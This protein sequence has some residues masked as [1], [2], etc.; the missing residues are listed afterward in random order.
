MPTAPTASALTSNTQLATTAYADTAVGVEATRAT[1]A[2]ALKAPLA[3]PA[4]TGTPTAPTKTALTNSTAIATTAYAD[5]AVAVVSLLTVTLTDAG[6]I[7][8]G[9]SAG[10]S[11]RVTLGGNRTLGNPSSPAYDG[12]EI[13][14]AV[15]QPASGGP[16]TLSYDT[17]YTFS[18]GLPQPTLTT[19]PGKRD[20]LKFKWDAITSKWYCLAFQNGF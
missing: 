13:I 6:T 18:V 20:F 5:A 8:V 19:T 10:N 4:L 11:F 7:A 14:L 2:E 15:I 16:W 3:S 17:Q 9:A 12:Q 1:A